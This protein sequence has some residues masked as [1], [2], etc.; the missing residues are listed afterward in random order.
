MPLLHQAGRVVILSGDRPARGPG[1]NLGL[2]GREL[3]SVT[4]FRLSATT[5]WLMVS[6]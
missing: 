3:G 5:W 6:T 1:A 4:G 2:F